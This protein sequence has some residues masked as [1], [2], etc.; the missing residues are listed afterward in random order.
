MATSDF[1]DNGVIERTHVA[2]QGLY[3][4]GKSDVG[5]KN[6]FYLIRYELR[7]S[8]FT[9]IICKRYSVYS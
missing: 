9:Q 8:T 3:T 2:L 6:M 1:A 4:V 5:L 7:R